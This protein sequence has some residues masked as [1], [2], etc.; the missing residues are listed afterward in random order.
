MDKTR[1]SMLAIVPL[2]TS[3][4]AYTSFGR[5]CWWLTEG[6]LALRR[7]RCG[8]ALQ[9]SEFVLQIFI[10]NVLNGIGLEHWLNWKQDYWISFLYCVLLV[11]D[12]YQPSGEVLLDS[13]VHNEHSPG[14][15]WR[16]RLGSG[17]SSYFW[18]IWY[19]ILP[20]RKAIWCDHRLTELG[21]IL[22]PYIIASLQ[23]IKCNVAPE[24]RSI[25]SG[26]LLASSTNAVRTCVGTGLIY[27]NFD[28]FDL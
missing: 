11:V 19:Q 25:C 12:V 15:L 28:S 3:C 5:P 8:V 27:P 13:I 16:P 24:S 6:S 22:S 2:D 7:K 10:F 4:K 26:T 14:A 21:R 17:E 9:G 20:R 23:R 1:I 18:K